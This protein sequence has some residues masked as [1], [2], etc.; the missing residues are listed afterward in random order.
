MP[1]GSSENG[2]AGVEVTPEMIEAGVGAYLEW[3]DRDM[4]RQESGR[5]ENLVV[6]ILQASLGSHDRQ[7]LLGPRQ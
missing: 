6:Q 4:I 1:Q 7:N 2:Q 3:L 5:L